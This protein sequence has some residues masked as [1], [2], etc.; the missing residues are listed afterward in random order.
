MARPNPWNSPRSRRG[1]GLG[2]QPHRL[3]PPQ[4]LRRRSSS[5]C[6]SRCSEAM[7]AFSGIIPD[8]TLNKWPKLAGPL[9]AA[10]RPSRRAAQDK[11][12]SPPPATRPRRDSPEA[13]SAFPW[14]PPSGPPPREQSPGPSPPERI[15]H[16]ISGD[17]ILPHAPA[18]T[19]ADPAFAESTGRCRWHFPPTANPQAPPAAAQRLSQSSHVDSR[20]P[21]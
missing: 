13:L 9:P 17:D 2:P 21:R 8:I 19:T 3:E 14:P 15:F 16:A 6:S 5:G 1:T 7:S 11:R 18:T 10:S 4:I 12:L 20:N